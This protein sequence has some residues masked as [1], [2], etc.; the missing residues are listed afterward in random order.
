[1]EINEVRE[2]RITME[3]VV[4]AYD[5]MERAMGWYYYLEDHLRFPF[6][7]N[8]LTNGSAMEVEVIKMASE[9]DCLEDMLVEVIYE[10]DGIKDVFTASLA[11]LQLVDPDK[12]TQVAID[13]WHYWLARGYGF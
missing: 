2:E 8:W 1:M 7:A 9:D 11:D 3:I 12:A 13:D 6:T 4:D 10:E 5:E